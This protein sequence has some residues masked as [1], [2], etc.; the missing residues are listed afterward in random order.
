MGWVFT[1]H[2]NS[3]C[4]KSTNPS[5]LGWG[6]DVVIQSQVKCNI[7]YSGLLT[8]NNQLF[9]VINKFVIVIRLMA[10]SYGHHLSDNVVIIKQ[11][12]LLCN[13]KV[14]LL[15]P[16]LLSVTGIEFHWSTSFLNIEQSY[17]KKLQFGYIHLMVHFLWVN[18][19]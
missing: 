3:R 14:L 4:F 11:H 18:P 10:A 12:A 15:F 19:D 1:R 13:P 7:V 17:C 8:Y 5:W 16:L 2:F 6:L 9:K